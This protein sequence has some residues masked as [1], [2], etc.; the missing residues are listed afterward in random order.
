MARLLHL[1]PKEWP[2]RPP[3]GRDTTLGENVLQK[4]TPLPGANFYETRWAT[5]VLRALAL[6]LS[7]AAFLS[8]NAGAQQQPEEAWQAQVRKYSDAHDWTN[9]L[10]IVNEQIASSPQDM[11]ILAWRARVLTWAGGLAEAERDFNTVLKVEKNDPDNWMGLANLYMRQGRTEEA[12]KAA[13]RA[14]ELDPNRGDLRSER[15]QIL[16]ASG[17][18]SDA[19]LE[20]RRALVLDPGDADARAGIFSLRDEG[21]QELRF[22]FDED[23]FSF[24]PSNYDQSVS[25]VSK[26]TPQWTTSVAG[27]F[28]QRDS[29]DAGEFVGSVTRTQPHWGALTVGGAT[30]HDNGVIPKT[31]AFFELDHG[32]KISENKSLRGLELTYGQHWY[33]YSL[34]RILTVNERALVYLP[35]D[36][37]WSIELIE[38]RSHFSGTNADWKPSGVTRLGF[39]LD[40]WSQRELSGNVFYALGTEDFA[41]I[42][43]IGSFASQT[44]GGGLRFRFTHRQDVAG[45]AAFQQRT[46]NRAQTSFG[47]SYGI[48]F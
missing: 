15:A 47:I 14:V 6:F 20:F 12:L 24:A 42:D 33:W 16:R 39:P 36:W 19:R 31:E 8:F 22:G 21:K 10:R 1:F 44:Y 48:R 29:I 40:H 46:Q 4:Q 2:A 5:S 35:H 38:A 13:D 25:L 30:G 9:A 7:G 45:Y 41:Q 28:Y 37:T 17:S 32:F 43:Q 26:W 11:D 23:M 34:A 18:L 27:S 3:F